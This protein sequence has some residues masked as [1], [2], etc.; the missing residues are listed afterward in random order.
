MRYLFKL[1]LK[2][3]LYEKYTCYG[4]YLSK[5]GECETLAYCC[6]GVRERRTLLSLGP[7]GGIRMP[8]QQLMHIIHHTY[9]Y[10]GV[11]HPGKCRVIL[12]GRG[13]RSNIDATLRKMGLSGG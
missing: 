3:N 5:M 7:T 6:V 8:T 12:A 11:N 2:F 9:L 10:E 4:Y 1:S 13:R